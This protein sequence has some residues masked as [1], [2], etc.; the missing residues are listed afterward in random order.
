MLEFEQNF[1]GTFKLNFEWKFS[2]G[3][4]KVAHL[5]ELIVDQNYRGKKIGNFLVQKAIEISNEQSCYRIIGDCSEKLV[6][7]YQKSGLEK[8]GIQ[9]GRYFDN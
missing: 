2:W 6:E 5:E 4:T 9:I 8:Q 7:F 3:G 1:I